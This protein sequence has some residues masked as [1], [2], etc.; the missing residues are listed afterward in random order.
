MSNNNFR[1]NF[2]TDREDVCRY[3]DALKEGFAKGVLTFSAQ[4][5]KVSLEPSEVLELSIETSARKGKVR[6]TLNFTWPEEEG[7][8]YHALPMDS[9]LPGK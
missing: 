9:Q 7:P 3:L 5:R 1:H 6:L 4:H 2:V 8:Q